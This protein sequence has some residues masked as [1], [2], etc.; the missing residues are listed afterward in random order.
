LLHGLGG[1][2]VSV[3]M[4]R[5]GSMLLALGV[6]VLR[7]DMR[8]AGAGLPLARRVYH[9]GRSADIRAALALMH[10]W[11]PGSP[12]LLVGVSLGG[13]LALGVAGE[14]LEHPV[15]GLRRV[16]ALSPPI[17]LALCERM[18]AQPRNRLYE[19]LFVR[20]VL[21]E[22]QRRQYYFPDL[23][24]LRFPRG[25]LSFRQFDDHY[26]APR[27]GFASAEDYYHRASPARLLSRIPIPTLIVT[28]RDDPFIAIEPFEEVTLSD[29]VSLYI[30]PQGGHIGFIGRDGA[31]G[32]RWAERRLVEWLL[33]E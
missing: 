25:R 27:S 12:L 19:D 6:R 24:P 8:G 31:G 21:G 3:H 30:L 28:A 13:N 17:D 10:R 32:V 20:D 33:A 26:T 2:A 9:S 29:Q 15:P 18:L 7:L 4:Q 11:S 16:A 23:P 5:L 14:M 22:A 1:S